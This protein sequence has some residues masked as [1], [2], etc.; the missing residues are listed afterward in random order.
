M[1]EL[2]GKLK[3]QM[4]VEKQLNDEIQKQLENVGFKLK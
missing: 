1:N 3:S 2:T 4:E